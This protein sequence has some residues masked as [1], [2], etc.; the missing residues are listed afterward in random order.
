ML[1]APPRDVWLYYIE[2]DPSTG[3]NLLDGVILCDMW[4]SFATVEE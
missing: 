2:Y 1:M 3:F 4:E